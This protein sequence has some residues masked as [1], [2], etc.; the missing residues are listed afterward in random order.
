MNFKSIYYPTFMEVAEMLDGGSS[1][2]GICEELQTGWHVLERMVEGNGLK[3]VARENRKAYT[4]ENFRK[5]Q[6]RKTGQPYYPPTLTLRKA[7]EAENFALDGLT[8]WE[9]AERIG[10][11]YQ[12][13]VRAYLQRI[14]YGG[15]VRKNLQRKLESWGLS[16]YSRLEPR[17]GG[18]SRNTNPDYKTFRPAPFWTRYSVVKALDGYLLVDAMSERFSTEYEWRS[19]HIAEYKES[20][21]RAKVEALAEK[22][23]RC[24]QKKL[25]LEGWTQD[26]CFDHDKLTKR[27][28]KKRNDPE[29]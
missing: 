24:W 9:I 6:A 18:A 14:G 13:A 26:R 5:D 2:S 25:A 15:I 8:C 3:D 20:D 17:I 4:G 16:P 28:R 29:S 19:W 21:G 22:L 7:R 23:N 10:P 27:Q 11:M 1:I 12:A